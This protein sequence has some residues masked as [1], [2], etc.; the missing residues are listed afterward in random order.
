LDQLAVK[1]FERNGQHL[2]GQGQ[3]FG[4][5]LRDV[6][7]KGAQ[8]RQTNVAGASL[9]TALFFQVIQEAQD[10]LAVPIPE[11][12]LTGRMAALALDKGQQ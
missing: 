5:L 10:G 12:L 4:R 8:G 11:G 6:T 9:A 1:A 7:H 2:A 3:R